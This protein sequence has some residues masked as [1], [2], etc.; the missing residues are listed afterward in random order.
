[1]QSPEERWVS[2]TC[3]MCIHSC[4][5]RVRVVDGVVVKIE[6]DA[7]NA[8]NQGKLCPK[9]NAGLMRLYDP[10][11]VK[12]P[13]RR[14]NPLKGYGI[15]PGWKEISWDEA[16]NEVAERL[17][18]IRRE[19]PRGL[20]SALGDFHRSFLWGWPAVF[21]APHVFSAVGTYCGASAHPLSGMVDGCFTNINDY[22]HC[23]YWIQIG[24]G[25]GFSSHLHLSGSAK[26]MADARMR[27]MK[28]VVIDP[29][30]S[31]AAAKAECV[32]NHPS[33]PIP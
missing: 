18:E 11:R 19:N 7:T 5:I 9:G 6:G 26:R 31:V 20:L 14:T 23:N 22:D 33:S 2:S 27:G 28:L 12:A 30:L 4:G 17:G 25:D 8:N 10:R 29:R 15:D 16:L 13:L 1:M 24:S 21:G 3:K 32:V